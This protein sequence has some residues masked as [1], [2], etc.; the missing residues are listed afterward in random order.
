VWLVAR[1]A[2]LGAAP[3]L[4]LL[5]FAV[6]SASDPQ[7]AAAHPLGNFTV[8]RYA[9]IELYSDAVRV[10]YVL[11]MAEIPAFQEIETIDTDG[12]G[13]PAEAESAAYLANRAPELL[14]NLNLSLGG[15]ERDLSVLSQSVT[16]PEGQAGLRTV[17]I[18]LL[19][20]AENA[21]GATS[22]LFS[23]DNYSDRVGWKEIV[24]APAAGVG[25]NDS[26]APTQNVS[27]ELTEYPGDLLS[28]PLDVRNV[29]ATFDATNGASAPA[30]SALSPASPE[31]AVKRAGGGFA[32]LVDTDNLTLTVILLSLLAAFGFGA[33]HA[34]EPGH[35]KTFV[36]A[37]FVGVKGSARE[38]MLLG[39][40]VAVTHTIGVFAIGL[41]TLFGSQFILPEKLYPWLSLASGLMVL[42]LGIRLLAMRSRGLR[43]LQRFGRPH[44]FIRSASSTTRYHEHGHSHPHTHT[45]EPPPAGSPW[46][47]LIALGLADGLTPSPSALIV[48]LAAVSLDRIG[49]GVLLIVAFSVG[50]AAVLTMVCLGLVYVR[51]IIDW[52]GRRSN[53]IATHPVLAWATGSGAGE[54]VLVTVVP[55]VGAFAL[56]AV[57]LV[58]TIR[59][60]PGTD[61]PVL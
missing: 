57:G 7:E 31:K 43:F 27:R 33:V 49:L 22:L 35:G 52:A 47:G 40:I 4:A 54:G 34:L 23:D 60:L 1:L 8:N 20:E 6:L 25:L 46:K 36:A 53:G 61:L 26:S 45:H 11:D 2:I 38:A 37:Y 42:L 41:L 29:T 5:A 59:A 21:A 51:R 13:D 24:V 14:A 19:L 44:T 48:L 50:L 30:V 15:E 32:S 18:D 17:R 56:T 58:L 9:R 12:N 16:Y 10:K 28:S 39:L 3:V 55:V